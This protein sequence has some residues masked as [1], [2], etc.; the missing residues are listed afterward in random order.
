MTVTDPGPDP[1]ATYQAIKDPDPLKVSDPS[2][3]K[4]AHYE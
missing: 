3:S 2:E 4:S 1:D